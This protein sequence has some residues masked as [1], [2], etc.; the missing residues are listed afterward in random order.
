MDLVVFEE[1]KPFVLEA[2]ENG[3]FDYI[4]AASEV[5]E[6]DF[7][8]YI[9]AKSI[10]QKI[11]ETYPSPRKKEEVPTWFYV[12]SNISLRLHGEN[13]FH[14]YPLIVRTGGMLNAFGPEAGRKV[15]H[16]DTGD[17]TLSCEGFNQKNQFDRETPCNED[18]LRKFA[19]DTDEERHRQLKCFSDLTHFTSRAFS[20]VVNQVVFILLAY[21]LLQIFLLRQGRE[22]LTK[23]TQPRIL[24]QL[25]PS[26]SY[27][28]VYW[29]NYYGLF[30]IYEFME[31]LTTANEEARKKIAEKSRRLRRELTETLKN[32]RPP[33]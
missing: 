10:L 24:K 18:F 33:P 28:I 25:L 19:K 22:D 17:V 2:L 29:Q 3:D 26:A 13:A 31:L 8:R 6:T 20:L 16:P 30:G 12:A 23:K 9:K 32:P 15:V 1:N 7:F 27:V 11:A 5:V 4:D 21:S 14:A